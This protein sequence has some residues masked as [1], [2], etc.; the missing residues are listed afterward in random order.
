MDVI[1]RN[2]KF[3]MVIVKKMVNFLCGR[4]ILFIEMEEVEVLSRI[5][6]KFELKIGD[7]VERKLKDGDILLLN[8][9]YALHRGS[10]I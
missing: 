7:L 10:M 8:R 3:K 6:R 2:G 4:M 1:F 9:P 5:K